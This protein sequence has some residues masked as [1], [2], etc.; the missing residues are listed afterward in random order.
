MCVERLLFV[1]LRMRYCSVVTMLTVTLMIGVVWLVAI[2]YGMLLRLSPVQNIVPEGWR[3]S[4]FVLDGA[5]VMAALLCYCVIRVS[6]RRASCADSVILEC[7]TKFHKPCKL[8]TNCDK[9]KPRE[10]TQQTGGTKSAGVKR[11]KYLV[12]FLIVCLHLITCV[13]PSWVSELSHSQC[14][15]EGLLGRLV[16][17][18]IRSFNFLFLPP[19]YL[20][21]QPKVR[22]LIDS[23]RADITHKTS[24]L[25][26]TMRS[27]IV[28]KNGRGEGENMDADEVERLIS[29]DGCSDGPCYES[30][31]STVDCCIDC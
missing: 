30:T 28:K 17:I 3:T 16:L 14:G 5:V 7:R 24:V 12:T 21:T 23:K 22:K 25:L 27:K 9:Q 8:A 20:F 13:V 26:Q 10:D 4:T 19:L 11:R 1:L 31:V 18:C 6:V 15:D 29:E 2:P